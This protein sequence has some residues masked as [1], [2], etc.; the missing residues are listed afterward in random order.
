MRERKLVLVANAE[1]EL[2]VGPLHRT[3]GFFC[4]APPGSRSSIARRIA[5]A[6]RSVYNPFSLMVDTAFQWP[7]VAAPPPRAPVPSASEDFIPFE[8]D[9]GDWE[10]PLD[11]SHFCDDAEAGEAAADA[12]PHS[13]SAAGAMDDGLV[14][15]GRTQAPPVCMTAWGL[16]SICRDNVSGLDSDLSVVTLTAML[17]CLAV[18][19]EYRSPSE[20]LQLTWDYL[21]TSS[22]HVYYVDVLS[23]TGETTTRTCVP[24]FSV[25]YLNRLLLVG[26][27]ARKAALDGTFVPLTSVS[28]ALAQ[29]FVA[30]VTGV[31]HA[32]DAVLFLARRYSGNQLEMANAALQT[33]GIDVTLFHNACDEHYQCTSHGGPGRPVPLVTVAGAAAMLHRLLGWLVV[34]LALSAAKAVLEHAAKPLGIVQR[35]LADLT[36]WLPLLDRRDLQHDTLAT[37]LPPALDALSRFAVAP[38]IE[39]WAKQFAATGKVCL[40]IYT[41]L[42]LAL[43]CFLYECVFCLFSVCLFFLYVCICISFFLFIFIS[44]SFY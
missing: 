37:A 28:P 17:R 16:A 8:A 27:N 42:F 39:D 26:Y 33:A 6:D 30:P 44:L 24:T 5:H 3:I 7:R 19:Q 40:C 2:S 32:P 43:P 38:L 29:T 12:V 20:S 1:G 4:K 36:A 11:L 18:G 14:G 15:S 31:G 25:E 23:G 10:A 34:P 41:S 21:K 35:S 22:L 9:Y 13:A